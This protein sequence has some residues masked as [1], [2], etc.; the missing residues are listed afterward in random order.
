MLRGQGAA[1]FSRRHADPLEV[2]GERGFARR[3]FAT[4]EQLAFNFGI[5]S[6]GP[7]VDDHA[8]GAQ[9]AAS[10][11]HRILAALLA[12]GHQQVLQEPAGLDVRRELRIFLIVA[13]FAHVCIAQIELGKGNQHLG[14]S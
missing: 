7:A 5:R 4:L 14:H 11:D 8:N 3:F 2:L 10:G 12:L 9:A 13:C 1:F 6:P